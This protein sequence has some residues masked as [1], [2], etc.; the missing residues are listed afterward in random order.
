VGGTL[1]IN[2]ITPLDFT[3]FWHQA[4]LNILRL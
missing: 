4:L 3:R 2:Y 1:D